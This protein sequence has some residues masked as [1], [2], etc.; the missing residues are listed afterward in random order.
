M[1]QSILFALL[2]VIGIFLITECSIR[3][4]EPVTGKVFVPANAQIAHGERL[5]MQHCQKCHPAGEGGLG[6]AI[7]PVP[8]PQFVKRFQVRH[9]LGV[10]PSFKK[11]EISDEDLKDIS[12]YMRAWSH[13]KKGK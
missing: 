9:G 13:A 2:L 10:M 8:V 12:K 1:K 11:D 5:F 7:N 4:S 6:L 3:K